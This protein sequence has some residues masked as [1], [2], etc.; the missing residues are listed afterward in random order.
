MCGEPVVT[1]PTIKFQLGFVA[2]RKRGPTF[3]SDQ[4]EDG[5]AAKWAHARCCPR[6]L[7][8][9]LRMDWC[10]LCDHQYFLDDASESVLLVEGGDC[11]PDGFRGDV[12][13]TGHFLCVCDDWDVPYRALTGDAT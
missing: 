1:G 6:V 5:D 10:A 2:Y 4:F 3:L 8:R 9:P 12:G 7:D 11:Q 13:G